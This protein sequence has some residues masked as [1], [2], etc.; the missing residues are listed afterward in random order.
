VIRFL[1]E[2]FVSV[3]VSQGIKGPGLVAYQT[4]IAGAVSKNDE[5][6]PPFANTSSAAS[7]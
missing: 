2:V 6:M 3:C 5:D 7:A 1:A 4:S